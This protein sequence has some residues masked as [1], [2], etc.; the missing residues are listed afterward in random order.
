MSRQKNKTKD[1]CMMRIAEVAHDLRSPL[2]GIDAMAQ[3]LRQTNLSPEQLRLV[4]GLCASAQHLRNVASGILEEAANHAGLQ[5]TDTQAMDLRPLM[6]MIALA[7]EARANAKG[8]G[9]CLQM[10]ANLAPA[11][12]ATPMHIRQ[13]LENF[14]DNA[15]KV[16]TQG[17]ISL[18]LERLCSDGLFEEL[19][20]SVTDTGPGF[21]QA[22]AA[23]LFQ[24]FTQLDNG[25]AGTGLGL[26]AMHRLVTA[27]GGTI[28]C[29][30]EVG[31]GA[32]FWFTLRLKTCTQPMPSLTILPAVEAAAAALHTPGYAI[33]IVDDNQANRMIMATIL[34]HFDCAVVEAST[35]EEALILLPLRCIDA[36]MMDHTLPGISGLD[37]VKRIRALPEPWGSLP[38]IPVTGR[39]SPQDKMAFAAAGANGFVEKPVT[40][41]A[42]HAALQKAL[43]PQAAKAA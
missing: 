34:E 16:T 14:L 6:A 22:E 36:V 13:I 5:S 8:I 15:L 1:P 28:G 38:I 43:S 42:I 29:S 31:K 33:L 41:A 32:T 19:R 35:A 37:A 10:D 20:W 4:E 27:M 11:F 25:I 9:F 18:H 39:V 26:S 7:G 21:T 3:L 40:P 17:M 24:D 23:T 12:E 30:G 2:G